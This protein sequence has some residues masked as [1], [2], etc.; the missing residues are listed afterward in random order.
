MKK[1]IPDT[2]ATGSKLL[3]KGLDT[4][5]WLL[6]SLDKVMENRNNPV[7]VERKTRDY[8]YFYVIPPTGLKRPA[9]LSGEDVGSVDVGSFLPR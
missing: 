8:R 3:A 6:K 7:W 5:K 4:E 2:A 9:K 1:A